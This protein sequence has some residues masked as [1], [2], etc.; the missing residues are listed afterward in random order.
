MCWNIRLNCGYKAH[1][2]FVP[3]ATRHSFQPLG[4]FLLFDQSG[5]SLFVFLHFVFVWRLEIPLNSKNPFCLQQ[6]GCVYIYN[7][8]VCRPLFSSSTL[9]DAPK[10]FGTCNAW[11]PVASQA[12]P[13]IIYIETRSLYVRWEYIEKLVDFNRSLIH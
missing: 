9:D 3:A 6:R 12:I 1:R 4:D 10:L 11:F 2:V 8:R 13:I 5:C 7:L